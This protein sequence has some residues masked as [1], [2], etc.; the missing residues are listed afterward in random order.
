MS[1]ARIIITVALLALLVAFGWQVGACYVANLQL[2][3][4]LQDLAAQVGT[5]IGLDPVKSDEDLRA[6]IIRK[7][8]SHDIVLR[9]DQI[10]V[11]HT[12]SGD[13]AVTYL[14]ADYTARVNL[15]RYSFNLHFTPSSSRR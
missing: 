3:D 4:D 2:Q 15:L 14:S 1:K 6:S 12:G 8:E 7:A 9:S 11:R 13:D 10:T 5:R